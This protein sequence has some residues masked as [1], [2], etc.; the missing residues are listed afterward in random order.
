[1]KKA[2]I[3]ERLKGGLI[4]SCQIET[5]APCYHE[6]MVE[7]MAKSALWGGAAGLRLNGA[8]NI[9]R[10][11]ALSDVPIIGLI[12]V[13][14][15]ESDVFMTPTMEEV[16]AVVAA[17]ADIVAVDGTD[18]SIHGRSGMEI[19]PMVK[20]AFPDVL[21]FAD[22]RDE[23]DALASLRLGADIV[24]PTFYRFKQ[25]AKSTDVPDWEMFARMCKT[26]GSKG[27]VMMEGKVWTPDD[28]IRAFHYGAHAVII[29][30]AITRPHLIM[31]RFYDHVH[32]FEEERS[33]LY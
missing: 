12:K 6:D 13:F 32:G 22:V 18:R 28:A 21:I 30:S 2:E 23:T 27:V 7:L 17:G 9:A 3:L 1:M 26:C 31:R 25:D 29:G 19:I 5:H 14:S 33:L 20:E 15:K 4:V 16:R 11:R 8:D 24:A 10:I